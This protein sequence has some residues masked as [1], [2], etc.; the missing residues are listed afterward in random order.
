M[1]KRILIAEDEDRI[2]SFLE[3]GLR[4]HGFTPSIVSDGETAYRRAVLGEHDLLIL[5]LGLPESDGFTV[6]RRLRDARSPIPVIVLTAR[7]G[8]EDTVAGLE[9]GADDYMS[10]PFHL[11]ELI[12]RIR[13]RLRD[14]DAHVLRFGRLA[15]NRHTRRIQLDDRTI[16]LTA[17]EFA[18]V[19]TFL[20]NPRQVLSREHLL[21][22]VW[23]D[24][25]APAS[26]VLEAYV[27]HL[28]RKLGPDTIITVRGRGYRLGGGADPG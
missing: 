10:K 12:A 27:R 13:R 9:A 22:T 21:S 26:N 8:V 16:D 3:H 7:D 18:L 1:T 2:A 6:L 19:E 14:D 17:R 28:R 5:D 15:L 11:E 4:R 23:G 25:D 20:L 24:G